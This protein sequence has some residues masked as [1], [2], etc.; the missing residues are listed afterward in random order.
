[1]AGSTGVDPAGGLSWW[2]YGVI[3]LVV[4][5][6]AYLFRA[7]R[8]TAEAST[9]VGGS[10]SSPESGGGILQKAR[11]SLA[12]GFLVP[13]AAVIIIAVLVSAWSVSTYMGNQIHQSTVN[14]VNAK[15]DQI[16]STLD[17]TH[18][19]MRDKVDIGMKTLLTHGK[20][21]G[22][23]SV[24]GETMVEKERVPILALGGVSQANAVGLVD[25]VKALAGGTATLFVKRGEDFVRVSTNVMKNDLTRAVG[26]LLDPKGK[27]IA[28]IRKNT[29]FYGVVEILGQPFFTGYEPMVDARGQTVGIWYVGYPISTLTELGNT[30]AQSRILDN[31]FVALVDAKGAI[32]FKTEGVP[33]E[34]IERVVQADQGAKKEGWTVEHK[35]FTPWGY[36]V[37]I[38]Y[39]EADI[40]KVIASTQQTMIIGGIV[41]AILIC[42]IVAFLV[43]RKIVTP[44]KTLVQAADKLAQGDIGV[45]IATKSVDEIGVLSRAFS[46]MVENIKGQAAAADQIAAGNLSLPAQAK[47]DADSLG[48]ALDRAVLSLRGLVSESTMLSNAAVAGKLGTRGNA[49]K[50]QGGYRDIVQGVNATLD[51]VVK[52]VQD[53]L[54]TLAVMATGDMTARVTADYQGDLRGIKESINRVGESLEEALQKVSSAVGATASASSQISSSTEEMAAGAQEQTSQAGEVASAVE[55][56]TKTILENSKNASVAAETAKQA[57]V[58]AEQGGKVVDDTVQ[59]M[60]RIAEVV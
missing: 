34:T 23:V 55:E 37:I 46:S 26:T 18:A 58:S 59:G 40:E 9:P 56:M 1:M 52:P 14:L 43:S 32:R 4:A 41:L 7:R 36:N 13:T 22:Q 3:V 30:I 29:A 31:G 51:A 38:A 6:C 33:A 53:G 39:P 17:A 21:M 28:A 5:G 2:W 19:L 8:K 45:S 60:R 49:E 42:G 12:V 16:V 27:A 47:S 48:K 54:A 44:V 25:G 57:R 11:R 35:P 10:G 24:Y 50:F 15:G 20:N